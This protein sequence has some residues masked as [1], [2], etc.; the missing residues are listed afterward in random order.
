MRDRERLEAAAARDPFARAVVTVAPAVV[1]GA[2]A[3]A[4]AGL[5]AVALVATVRGDVLA[6]F[7]L[8]CGIGVATC[9]PIGIAN[10]IV[11]D[12]AC[13]HG[14]ARAIGAGIGG[15]LA[16]G[17]YASLGIFGIGPL[18]ARDPVIPY[19][20]HAISGCVLV[21]YGIVLWRSRQP[22]AAAT[23]LSTGARDRGQL[24]RGLG[25]GLAAT[26]LNP[27][28]IVTW[29]VIVGSHAVGVSSIKGAAWVFGIVLG[30]FGW[31]VVVTYFAL[32]SSRVLRS[33]AAWLTRGL[34][35]LVIASGLWSLALV[36]RLVWSR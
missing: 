28:A 31:F 24:R 23:D 36:A 6:F 14:A 17:V 12:S 9:I 4:L 26:L 10:V 22:I 8:G 3:V 34:G 35:L 18:L 1:R 19:V 25:I 29:V 5:V 15:A 13:R 20:L 16:D 30:T 32:R 7:A 11:I 21:G 2:N 27:S 33:G